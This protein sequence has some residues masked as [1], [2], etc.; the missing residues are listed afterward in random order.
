[1]STDRMHIRPASTSDAPVIA[2]LVRMNEHAIVRQPELA[3]PFW[4]GMSGP[5]HEANIRSGRFAYFVAEIDGSAIGFIAMRDGT[6]LF[7]LFVHPEWFRR[8][9]AS[10]LWAHVLDGTVPPT[11]AF[12]TVNASLNAVP[13]YEALGFERVGEDVSHNGVDFMPMRFH[14]STQAP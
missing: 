3:G 8:G 5:S 14:R 6:H 1:M 11:T 9:V 7:N 12:V 13:V 2:A 4:E 10:A